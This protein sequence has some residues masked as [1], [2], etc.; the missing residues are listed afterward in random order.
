MRM[1]L[2][3]WCRLG[4]GRRRCQ[5][6]A[7]LLVAVP[8]WLR[9]S[10]GGCGLTVIDDGLDSLFRVCDLIERSR[11]FLIDEIPFSLVVVVEDQAGEGDGEVRGDDD[12]SDGPPGCAAQGTGE[13]GG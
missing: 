12:G 4:C 10:C 8:G 11:E 5:G 7:A 3:G 9:N 1:L 2:T 13:D 6:A